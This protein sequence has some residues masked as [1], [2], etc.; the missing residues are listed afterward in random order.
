MIRS[1]VSFISDER[2]V[3]V[4]TGYVSTLG[5]TAILLTTILIGGNA[6]VSG[7]MSIVTNNQLEAAGHTLSGEIITMRRLAATP[8]DTNQE[9]RAVV[10]LPDDTVNGQYVIT[11]N[12]NSFTLSATTADAT[13]TIQLPATNTDIELTSDG[14]VNGGDVVLTSTGDEILIEEYD[15]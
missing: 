3:T 15:V 11:T 6:I 9:L 1:P 10:E 2:A 13:Q 5:M 8:S 12:A 14:R 4:A 7:E